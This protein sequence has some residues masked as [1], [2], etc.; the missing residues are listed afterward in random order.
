MQTQRELLDWII[1]FGPKLRFARNGRSKVLFNV[2]VWNFEGNS[3]VRLGSKE[4]ILIILV[5][6]LSSENGFTMKQATEKIARSRGKKKERKKKKKNGNT[7]LRCSK[8]DMNR[9]RG[10]MP[11][12]ISG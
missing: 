9:Y 3:L 5:S 12:S 4:K 6:R 1:P 2:L 7:S 10:R 8:A 11:R